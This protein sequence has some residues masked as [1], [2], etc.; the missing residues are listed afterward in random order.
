ML[1]QTRYY[2]LIQRLYEL[3]N[4]DVLDRVVDES[5]KFA[6]AELNREQ[7]MD[8]ERSDGTSLPDYSPTSVNVYG[9]PSGPIK[10]FDTGAF[11]ESIIVIASENAYRFLSSPLKRD[12]MTGR[13]TNLKEKYGEEI[14]G[15]GKEGL[16]EIRQKVKTK[17]VEYVNSLLKG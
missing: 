1:E 2:Q 8:G 15:L 4:I 16:D 14:I 7:L 12:E 17:I 9:K 10:L 11:Q 5:I 3:R 6:M 13:I